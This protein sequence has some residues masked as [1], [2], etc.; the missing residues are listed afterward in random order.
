MRAGE[1]YEAFAS[2]QDDDGG[3][4][5]RET[6]EKCSKK[7]P[8]EYLP[9]TAAVRRR[10]SPTERRGGNQVEIPSMA[11]SSIAFC[12]WWA[13]VDGSVHVTRFPVEVTLQFWLPRIPCPTRLSKWTSSIHVARDYL[14]LNAPLTYTKVTPA[15]KHSINIH[16]SYPPMHV[17]HAPL[18]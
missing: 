18:R 17:V 13:H 14:Q 9:L 4:A 15:A 2:V 1:H 3:S 16:Q 7:L 8:F 10:R 12:I 5:S 11:I 6:N